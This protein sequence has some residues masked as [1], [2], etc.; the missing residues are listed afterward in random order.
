MNSGHVT[1]PLSRATPDG[2]DGSTAP[3]IDMPSMSERR[4][5]DERSSDPIFH[6]PRKM[7]SAASNYSARLKK[8]AGMPGVIKDMVETMGIEPTTSGLQSPRS[9]N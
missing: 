6:R 9:P 4:E 3:P 2:F 1:L 8:N 7:A 5:T